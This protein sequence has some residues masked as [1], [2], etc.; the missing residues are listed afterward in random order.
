MALLNTL[1]YDTGIKTK[2]ETLK[3]SLREQEHQIFN[4]SVGQ[5][6]IGLESHYSVDP[7]TQQSLENTFS[8]VKSIIETSM[9]DMSEVSLES[10][11]KAAIGLSD[12]TTLTNM[13][14][15]KIGLEAFSKE[16]IRKYRD[17][18]IA[19]NAF[20]AED[21]PVLKALYP[22]VDVGA[23][24]AG[25]EMRLRRFI[26]V[27]NTDHGTA[28]APTD[29]QR[30]HI[31]AGYIDASFMRDGNNVMYPIVVTGTN[32]GMFAD[33]TVI[34][35]TTIP[36]SAD[37]TGPINPAYAG[38]INLLALARPAGVSEDSTATYNDRID[39]GCGLSRIYLQVGAAINNTY[40]STSVEAFSSTLF[41]ANM[42]GSDNNTTSNFT[43]SQIAYNLVN[44][45]I[46][47][48]EALAALGYTSIHFQVTINTQLNL[49]TGR[50][51]QTSTV[52]VVSGLFKPGDSTNYVGDSPTEVA[53]VDPKYIGYDISATLSSKTLRLEGVRVDDQYIPYTFPQTA[54]PVITT[55]KAVTETDIGD[56]ME[57]MASTDLIAR[58]SDAVDEVIKVINDLLAYS[59]KEHMDMDSPETRMPG[60]PFITGIWAKDEMY[61]VEDIVDSDKSSERY[62]DIST[63]LI[64]ILGDRASEMLSDT[65]L[66]E[67]KR[68][69][70]KSQNLKIKF[71]IIT[72]REIG[73]YLS[74]V[75]DGRSF[76]ADEQA[77]EPKPEIATSINKN[78]KDTIIMVPSS[79]SGDI[80]SFD[81]FSFGN[82][83]R[84]TSLVYDVELT[85]GDSHK[86]HL[87]LQPFY[88]FVTN[89]PIVLRLKVNGL[90]E[91]LA[92]KAHSL[93]KTVT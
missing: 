70:N 62:D 79:S 41:T 45:G 78:L 89:M 15:N 90:S 93:H 19:M 49:H 76:G 59:D 57:V 83:L 54:R 87:Q 64:D 52:P 26:H 20:T 7:G 50:L 85:R 34:P 91:F 92:S 39:L 8:S 9:G 43:S 21:S 66:L 4:E 5:T 68:I 38:D 10:A 18:S 56:M 77:I 60:L 88:T 12:P 11:S 30:K 22:T 23:Q 17:E 47:E 63:S 31:V 69:Y 75:G 27:G 40:I 14:R 32:E 61:N 42:V 33:P 51:I 1:H 80:G 37:E 6:Y 67:A 25:I 65:N 73:R 16:E 74:R 55:D 58:E 35:Y 86:R 13:I 81:P 53:A 28:G 24:Y 36:G 2:Y 71:S 44:T 72:D 82:T 46:A 84:G 29:F 3:L 48:L